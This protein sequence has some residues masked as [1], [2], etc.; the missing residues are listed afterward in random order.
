MHFNFGFLVVLLI[1][2]YVMFH[3]VVKVQCLLVL[4]VNFSGLLLK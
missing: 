1:I 4:V 2:Q 3:T